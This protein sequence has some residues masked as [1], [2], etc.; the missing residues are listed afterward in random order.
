MNEYDDLIVRL[1]GLPWTVASEDVISFLD[2]CCIDDLHM[3]FNMDGR[4]K[5]EAYVVLNS[6]EDLKLA[7]EKHRTY[8]GNRYI[9]VTQVTRSEMEF[10]IKKNNTPKDISSED[11]VVK[12][13]GLPYSCDKDTLIEFF[14]NL[15]VTPNGVFV[16]TDSLGRATGDAY[17]QFTSQAYADMALKKHKER[18]GHRYIEIYKSTLAEARTALSAASK[19]GRANTFNDDRKGTKRGADYDDYDGERRSKMRSSNFISQTGYS[20]HMRGLPYS[21]SEA[22][23]AEFFYPISIVRAVIEMNYDGRPSGNA[24]VDF[25][26]RDDA[27]QAMKKDRESI[28]HRYVEL[29]YTGRQDDKFKC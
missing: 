26:T 8:I 21:T 6:R 27:A 19:A 23:I 11:A 5:G 20:V 12:L 24:N 14:D 2:C 1:R 29:F 10:N 18:I 7:V 17:V 9:D 3:M 22:D 25:N 16:T 13:R 15:P 4:P 28:K